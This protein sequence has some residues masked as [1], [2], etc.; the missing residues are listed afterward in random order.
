MHEAINRAL[1]RRLDV[2]EA[3]VRANLEVLAAVLVDEGAAEYAEAPNAGGQRDRSGYLRSGALD[4]IDDFRRRGVE[5]P[6]VE[7]TEFN[8]NTGC[9]CHNLLRHLSHHTCTDSPA[10]FTNSKAQALF[11]R[12][13]LDE[14]NI[15]FYVVPRHHHLHPIG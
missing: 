3:V 5:A 4:R 2:D 1:R 14:F 11:H 12:N 8:A 15:K 7:R 10:T 13:R 6:V 9:S